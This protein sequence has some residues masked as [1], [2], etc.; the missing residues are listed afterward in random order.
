MIEEVAGESVSGVSA[1]TT[2]TKEYIKEEN[3]KTSIEEM[4]GIGIDDRIRTE[5]Q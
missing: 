4:I 5:R 3:Q 1:E 2:N